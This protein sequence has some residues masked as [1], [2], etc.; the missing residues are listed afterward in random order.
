[1]LSINTLSIFNSMTIII[2]SIRTKNWSRSR[3][4]ISINCKLFDIL[5]KYYD[6]FNYRIKITQNSQR[7]EY[8]TNWNSAIIMIDL[9]SNNID[10]KF[11]WKLLDLKK[12]FFHWQWFCVFVVMQINNDLN[13]LY[14]ILIINYMRLNKM[15]LMISSSRITV[16]IYNI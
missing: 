3:F 1:M 10:S 6:W 14:E 12:S 4:S 2:K 15:C 16:D 5:Y 7:C 11:K 8:L 13:N 9:I